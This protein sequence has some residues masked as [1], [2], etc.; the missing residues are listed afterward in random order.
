MTQS[1]DDA[2]REY[3]AQGGSVLSYSAFSAGYEAQEGAVSDLVDAIRLTVE[4]LG[5]DTLP[6]IE[7]WSWFDALNE[8]APDV[9]Q[10]FVDH[11]LHFSKTQS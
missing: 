1:V 8:Y 2:W 11:P 9:A 4:Y 10:Q 5:N 3:V 7:G 6:A